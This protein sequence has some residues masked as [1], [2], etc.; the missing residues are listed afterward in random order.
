MGSFRN[1]VEN[2][3]FMA[4]GVSMQSNIPLARHIVGL[5]IVDGLN[6]T[7]ISKDPE[8]QRSGGLPAVGSISRVLRNYGINPQTKSLMQKSRRSAE[9]ISQ[10]NY[11]V[12]HNRNLFGKNPNRNY[13]SQRVQNS[14][15][16]QV[17]PSEVAKNYVA[18]PGYLKVRD[19]NGDIWLR[20]QH[21]EV[22]PDEQVIKSR[23]KD[24]QKIL[25]PVAPASNQNIAASQIA[26]SASNQSDFNQVR[27]A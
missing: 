10:K 15:E 21:Y 19:A 23:A 6:A 11:D 2:K 13:I 24:Y 12:Y 8:V 5:S 18:P 7:Q 9:D 17:L 3:D 1:W 4:K 26:A 25:K 22:Q 27:V 16:G 14:E 20:P